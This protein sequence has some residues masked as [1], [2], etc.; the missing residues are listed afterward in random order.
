[1]SSIVSEFHGLAGP[2]TS[3][4]NQGYHN[5]GCGRGGGVKFLGRG[6]TFPL[7][8]KKHSQ[9]LKIRD[10]SKNPFGERVGIKILQS[11]VSLILGVGSQNI[12]LIVLRFE[13]KDLGALLLRPATTRA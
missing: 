13:I 11:G 9:I 4:V 8:K 6:K 5:P 7:C 10:F 12:A 1:M 3:A 2:S